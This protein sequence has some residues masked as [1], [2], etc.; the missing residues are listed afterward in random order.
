MSWSVCPCCG[1]VAIRPFLVDLGTNTVVMNEKASRLTRQQAEIVS[2]LAAAYP[3]SVA[4]D[5]IIRR[6]YGFMP[7]PGDAPSCLK[8]QIHHARKRLAADRLG[9]RI[10]TVAGGRSIE[11]TSYRLVVGEPVGAE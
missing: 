11:G 1:S 9:L 7:E 6:V 2:V 4:T 8:A 3:G 10:D 5:S